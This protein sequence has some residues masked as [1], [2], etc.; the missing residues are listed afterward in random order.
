MQ[1]Y[2]RRGAPATFRRTFWRFA[3]KRRLLATIEWLRLWPNEGPFPQTKQ[4]L[5]IARKATNALSGAPG[6]DRGQK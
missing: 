1:T 2:S 6:L 5:G 3:L 4:T